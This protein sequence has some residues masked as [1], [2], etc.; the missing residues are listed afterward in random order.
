MTTNT[1]PDSSAQ[2]TASIHI[3]R[4]YGRTGGMERYVWELTH[5]LAKAKQPTKIICEKAHDAFSADLDVIELGTIKPKPRWRSMQKFS[6][7][8]SDYL[9]SIDSSGWVVH[10]HERCEKHQVTTFHGPSI[11]DRKKRLFDCLS[12]RIKAWEFLEKR[13]ILSPNV[14]VVLPNS[15]MVAENLIRLYP[16]VKEK[17]RPPAYPGVSEAF[18]ALPKLSSG[19]SIGF[20]GKE[21]QRKGLEFACQVLKPLILADE[22]LTFFVA[23]PQPEEVLH[24]FKDWPTEQYELLG[25][26]SAEDVLP[27]IDVLIHPATSEPF[28]MV[29]AEANAADKPVIVSDHCGIAELIEDKAGYVL[30]LKKLD[31]WQ[32][33]VQKALKMEQVAPLNLTWETLADQHSCLYHEILKG[34]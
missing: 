31:A 29:V 34:Q 26:S 25:W 10:S 23:G 33:A 19:A 28:G 21:W 2:T 22:A 6:Q 14:S 11:L 18:F 3:V 32:N 5:A 9:D 4:Q 8:V 7:K 13:E 12:P 27:R 15:K 24:L 30:P 17:I 1:S 20:I 16:Q